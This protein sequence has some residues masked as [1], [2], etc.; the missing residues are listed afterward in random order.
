MKIAFLLTQSLDGPLGIGRIGPL[1]RELV[2]LGHS[3][4]ILGLHPDFN[5]LAQKKFVLDGVRVE[6]VAQMHVQEHDNLKTYFSPG[7]MLW[8]ATNAAWQLTRAALRV[9]AEI[10]HICKPHMM[11][12]LAG[13]TTRFLHGRRLFLDCDDYEA[14]SGNFSANWQKMGVELFEKCLPR[15]VHCITTN[16]Y[17]LRDLLVQWGIPPEKIVYLSNGV[18]RARFERPNSE[19]LE[20]LR[21]EWGLFGKKVI[22][23]VGSLSMPSH[24]VDLLITA[25]RKVH[26]ILPNTVLML[27]GG[28]DQ[29]EPLRRMAQE[30]GVGSAVRFCGRI[31]PEKTVLYYYA[32]D[33]SVDPVLSDDSAR[34]RE[35]LKLFESWA[36]GIPFVT[37]D[38]GDRRM[39]ASDPPAILFARPGDP[40]SLAEAIQ[41]IL[42]NPEL[43]DSL[44]QRGYQQVQNYYWDH[45]A[46]KMEYVYRNHIKTRH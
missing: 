29:F 32:A 35:P 15:L 43:A 30:L 11:N 5:T 4:D 33:V 18:D 37:A 23:F 7:K 6:Y 22:V 38:V 21:T 34:G 25:F 40:D 10:I 8:V 13:L 39:L 26:D 2:R 42:N 45:L 17:F 24:P 46:R 1:A 19:Q 14:E 27:A 16:T 20:A 31:P 28:G 3:I 12:G 36:C 44:R 9:D 41:Q